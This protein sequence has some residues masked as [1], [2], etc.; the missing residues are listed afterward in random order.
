MKAWPLLA[1]AFSYNAKSFDI[2]WSTRPQKLLV[3][4]PWLFGCLSRSA[5]LCAAKHMD[6]YMNWSI[7]MCYMGNLS[8]LCLS[9]WFEWPLPSWRGEVSPASRSETNWK[10]T[11]T[12]I[13]SFISY[14]LDIF[15]TSHIFK[16]WNCHYFWIDHASTSS[17][18]QSAHVIRSHLLKAHV[19]SNSQ[20]WLRMLQLHC[21]LGKSTFCAHQQARKKETR[22]EV[23]SMS[24]RRMDNSLKIRRI[25]KV[26]I[27][28]RKYP[29]TVSVTKSRIKLPCDD[30]F[31]VSKYEFV[32][33]G[34][35]TIR[36]FVNLGASCGSALNVRSST[37]ATGCFISSLY[38]A[39]SLL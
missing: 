3:I 30:L 28:W 35:H 32:S 7:R 18:L 38:Q 2:F 6:T 37:V 20:A 22:T 39:I 31:P 21:N 1:Q 27:R 19:S 29:R 8:W 16:S 11:S 25:G 14:H 13:G 5:F 23:D 24:N 9:D 15:I 33:Q 4:V 17:I 12:M 36:G 10:Q 34:M 26:G